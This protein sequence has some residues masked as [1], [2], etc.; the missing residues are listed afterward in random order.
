M[1]VNSNIPPVADRRPVSRKRSFLSGIVS[2]GDGAYSFRCAIKNVS[3][4]GARLHFDTANNLPARFWLLN[5]HDRTAHQVRVAW[6]NATE[7]GVEF[8][9]AVPLHQ[10]PHELDYLKK[11]AGSG[12]F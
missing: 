5:L 9:N 11:L 4:T 7:A 1:Q 3:P 8:E 6:A 12:S 2:Y 10:L